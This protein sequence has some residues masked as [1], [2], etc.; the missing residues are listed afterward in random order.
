[1]VSGDTRTR[2]AE[3]PPWA[4]CAFPAGDGTLGNGDDDENA[5]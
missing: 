1:M 4:G 2:A 3:E 5:T